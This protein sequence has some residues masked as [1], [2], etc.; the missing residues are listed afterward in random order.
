M[1]SCDM[2]ARPRFRTMS[3][4]SSSHLHDCESDTGDAYAPRAIGGIS[5]SLISFGCRVCHD[6]NGVENM[7]PFS[8]ISQWK[9]SNPQL[10]DISYGNDRKSSVFI[11]RLTP[12]WE[13]TA[14]RGVRWV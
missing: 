7:L 2:F 5:G 1:I 11:S 8:S 6:S 4:T 10:P 12:G 13:G 9:E 3:E 14:G